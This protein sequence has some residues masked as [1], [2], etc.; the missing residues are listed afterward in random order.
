MTSKGERKMDSTIVPGYGFS[1]HRNDGRYFCGVVESVVDTVNGLRV[2]IRDS[3]NCFKTLYVNDLE[4]YR[5]FPAESSQA[6]MNYND[7]Y[8]K[9]VTM[10]KVS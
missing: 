4:V 6:I 10:N 8:R 7:L 9:V 3:E 2:V 1:A 5:C